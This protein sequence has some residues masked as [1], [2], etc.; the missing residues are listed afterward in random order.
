MTPLIKIKVFFND[1][2]EV[3]GIYDSGSNISLIN[4]KLIKMN[5]KKVSNSERR[6]IKTINGVRKTDGLICVKIKIF[7][8]EKRKNLIVINSEYINHDILIGLDC[9]KEFNLCQDEN[10]KITQVNIQNKIDRHLSNNENIED[11]KI[12]E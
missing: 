5:E 12:L 1:F 10:L 7:E 8:I 4:S 11:N 9:I 3:N 2:I 6:N